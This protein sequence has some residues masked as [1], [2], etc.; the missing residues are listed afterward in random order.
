M[1]ASSNLVQARLRL[2]VRPGKRF[3]G[4]TRSFLPSRCALGDLRAGLVTR[5]E[6]GATSTDARPERNILG[7]ALTFAGLMGIRRY[8]GRMAGPRGRPFSRPR[9][10]LVD[11][12]RSL[13]KAQRPAQRRTAHNQTANISC[14][15]QLFSPTRVHRSQNQALCRTK[16]RLG[17][18]TEQT[19]LEARIFGIF[20]LQA[21]NF[22]ESM[23]IR[24]CRGS[25]HQ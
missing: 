15:G 13:A 5:P 9:W 19:G 14:P 22:P 18:P 1:R 24:E 2:T 16:T 17:K 6:R 25:G 12:C 23:C 4:A 8:R 11:M 10:P 20:D 7:E 21:V 3:L